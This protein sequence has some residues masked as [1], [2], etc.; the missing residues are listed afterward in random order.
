MHGTKALDFKDFCTILNIIVSGNH[1]TESGVKDID[2]IIS[3]MNSKRY[4]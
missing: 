2:N 4:P 3:N 1:L